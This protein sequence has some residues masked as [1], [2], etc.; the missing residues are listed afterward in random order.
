MEKLESAQY[1]AALAVT[2]TWRGISCDRLYAELGWE[3]LSAHRWSRLTLFCKI[4]NNLTPLYT[5]D[6]LPP[7]RQS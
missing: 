6:P 7:L 2:G 4:I 5:K 3:T 1:S